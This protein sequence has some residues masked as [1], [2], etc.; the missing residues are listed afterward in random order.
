MGLWRKADTVSKLK[1]TNMEGYILLFIRKSKLLKNI[2]SG[3][4][5]TPPANGPF[6][7]P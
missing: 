4:A 3:G 6:R 1:L 5:N 7:H 2:F